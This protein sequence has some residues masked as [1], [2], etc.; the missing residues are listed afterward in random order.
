MSGPTIIAKISAQPGRRDEL[1]AALQALVDHVDSE[2]GTLVYVM[3]KD[4]GDED[5]VWFYEH[6]ASQD[7][8]DAHVGSEVMKAVGT[9]LRGIAAGR[10]ELTMLEVVGGKGL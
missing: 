9:G 10:P 3:H 8:L 2:A 6:Y 7:A 1:I 4:L 5:V